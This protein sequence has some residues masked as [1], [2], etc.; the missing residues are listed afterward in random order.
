MPK[1]ALDGDILMQKKHAVHK[2]TDQLKCCGGYSLIEVL[3]TVSIFAVLAGAINTVLL[4]GE[5][6][7]QTNSVQLELQQELRKAMDWMKDDLR[8]TGPAAISDGPVSAND[9]DYASIT[10]QKATGIS[11][12][13]IEW[14]GGDS[15]ATTQFLLGGTG[16][17]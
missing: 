9:T 10:F 1:K 2:M 6:S 4:I 15:D 8:Q 3:V 13:S 7:W 12:S 14:G 5:S 16:G 11:G 17:N